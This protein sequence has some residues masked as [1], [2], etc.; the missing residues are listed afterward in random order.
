M[1]TTVKELLPLPVR[2][3][4]RYLT[5]TGYRA[6]V[7]R[8]RARGRQHRLVK[9]ASSL[10]W[11]LTGGRIASGPFR[12]GMHYSNESVGSE[13]A[14]KL[15]GTYELELWAVVENGSVKER[16]RQLIDI[17]A[18]EGYYAAGLAWRIPN[19]HIVAFEAQSFAHPLIHRILELNS[20]SGRVEING[21]CTP[22]IL[23]C[24]LRDSS[25]V[26]ICNV[27]GA[28]LAILDP[29]IVPGLLRSDIL[30]ELHEWH[31]AHL[32]ETI[33]QRFANTHLIEPICTRQRTVEQIASGIEFFPAQAKAC[34]DE[35]RPGPMTWFWMRCR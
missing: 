7:R 35:F 26:I 10:L 34:M 8:Q 15:L 3:A 23:N 18:G 28:E 33:R 11:E 31:S 24:H 17:G 16:P 2:N 30:V 22:E 6:M 12:G 4:L 1:F 21:I 9:E 5:H 25:A 32:R 20:A 19:A 13:W 27:E 14:P 29:S